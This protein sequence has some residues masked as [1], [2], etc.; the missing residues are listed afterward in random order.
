[1]PPGTSPQPTFRP[2]LLAGLAHA[3]LMAL[4]FPRPGLW[5]F[6]LIAITPLVLTANAAAQSAKPL[7][8][9]V[10]VALGSLPF[11]AFTHWYVGAITD[12]GLPV[13]LLYL[14][15]WPGLF[16]WVMTRVPAPRSIWAR[17]LIPALIWTCV[18]SVRANWVW[19]GYAW[20]LV[21]Q[22]LIDT[23]A[24][25]LA[26]WFGLH[27]A[28]LFA[29]AFASSA[30]M[31]FPVRRAPGLSSPPAGQPSRLP[32]IHR[33]RL[34]LALCILFALLWL[35]VRPLG[36]GGSPSFQTVHLAVVQPNVPQSNKMSPSFDQRMADFSTLL[37]LT[38]EA[39]HNDPKPD[40][41]FWPETTFP[42][43]SLS[44]EVVEIERSSGLGYR[45]H[46]YPLTG[47]HDELTRVQRDLGVPMV[48]GAI[49]AEGFRINTDDPPPL[50]EFDRLFNSAFLILDGTV[51]PQRTDKVH[52]TPFGETMPLI[53]NWPW[54]ERRLLALGAAG[55]TFDLS[56]GIARPLTIPLQGRDGRDRTPLHVA[57][58]ICFEVTVPSVVR[59]QVYPRDP[60][61]PRAA[62]IANLTN[63]AWLGGSV[64]ARLNH[65]LAARWR[66]VE[67][68]VPM[69]RAANSGASCLIDAT[70]RVRQLG[71]NDAPPDAPR[72]SHGC[73]TE[74][75]M[76]VRLDVAIIPDDARSPWLP[77]LLETLLPA[78]GTVLI[79]ARAAL[80]WRERRDRVSSRSS[81]A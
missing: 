17:I 67:L 52:L 7:R 11:W 8:V 20:Y 34:A 32:A 21:G 30:A 18:E 43:T 80:A 24:T 41:I 55:M 68:G 69:I 37:R 63:D 29:A 54:L 23:S 42:G 35:P 19:D 77:R 58:P 72:P 28:S 51:Q 9:A 56:P 75:V 3:A 36:W 10:G 27:A 48:V 78:L 38:S 13:L 62:L 64:T 44:P 57:V 33:N 66:C 39:A 26:P 22:P 60:S 40:A 79:L 61:L 31:L 74:G 1:M 14:S 71:P 76:S 16:V 45:D 5:P 12:A 4:A 50:F 65:L 81:P 53:S 59:D 46:N 25:L 6:A 2:A 73:L 15:I 70:G 47:W 49:A